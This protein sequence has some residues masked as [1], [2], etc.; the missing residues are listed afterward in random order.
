[1]T[2]LVELQAA[3]AQIVVC[4]CT[5]RILS[6]RVEPLLRV[7]T[8]ADDIIFTDGVTV[9]PFAYVRKCNVD[10]DDDDECVCM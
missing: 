9:C 10:D 2:S 8:D 3:E 7:I 4:N 5:E 6:V 1:M